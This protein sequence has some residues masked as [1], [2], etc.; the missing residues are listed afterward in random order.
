MPA[1]ITQLLSPTLLYL[2][3]CY[4]VTLGIRKS[5]ELKWPKLK[6]SDGWTDFL[7]VIPVVV[8]VLFAYVPKYPIP[9]VFI[10]SWASKGMWGFV[11]G[12]CSTWSYMILQAFFKRVFGVDINLMKSIRPAAPPRIDPM[13]IPTIPPPARMGALTTDA[14][15]TTEKKP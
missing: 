11:A 10:G 15:V 2:L 13:N 9:P 5:A 14:P 7:P 8:G 4:F 1:D 3:F 6:T 12:A